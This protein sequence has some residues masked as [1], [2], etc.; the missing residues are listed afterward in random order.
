MEA[1]TRV[2]PVRPA[3]M[4][5]MKDEWMKI[6]TPVVEICK[7]QIRMNIRGRAV[8]MRTCEHTE[9]PS[10]L[11]RS[12]QYIEAINA[13]F[14]VEDAIAVLKFSDVFLD[15]L[16]ISEVKT[17]KGLHVERA[18][19]R[20]IGREGKTKSAIEEFSRSKVVVKDQRIHLLGTVEN[21]R[22]AKDAVCRLIMGSQPG[23]VFNRLR[24]INSRL[25]EK[26]GGV[27]TVYNNLEKKQ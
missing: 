13:G 12:A 9:D 25:K 7:V 4:K 21:T 8:E 5:S 22:I 27:Q 17:L 16:E 18:I 6:Y 20:I 19:G 15:H 23:S 24:I 14:P 2:V 10:H 1:Q 3:R 26:Y 11:E